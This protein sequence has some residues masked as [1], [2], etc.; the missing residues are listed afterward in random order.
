MYSCLSR[1]FAGPWTLGVKHQDKLPRGK[2]GLEMLEVMV[3]LTVVAV[4]SFYLCDALLTSL[5]DQAQ[6]GAQ[7]MG[8]GQIHNDTIHGDGQP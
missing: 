7:G 8:N 1:L 3:A 2:Y 4:S 5:F 6:D